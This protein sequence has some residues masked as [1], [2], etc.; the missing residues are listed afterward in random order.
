MLLTWT[1][2]CESVV[3]VMKEYGKQSFQCLHHV[4][5]LFSKQQADP[6]ARM[7]DL[8]QLDSVLLQEAAQTL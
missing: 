8:H 2:V 4:V 3:P 6:A 1:H 7:S 5:V